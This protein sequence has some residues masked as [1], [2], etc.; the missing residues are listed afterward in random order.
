VLDKDNLDKDHLD[1]HNSDLHNH[2]D[3]DN[4]YAEE[5]RSTVLPEPVGERFTV[6]RHRVASRLD[7]RGRRL[8]AVT[9]V[10]LTVLGLGALAANAAVSDHAPSPANVAAT[11]PPSDDPALQEREDAAARPDRAERAT[12]AEPGAAEP[13]E[14]PEPEPSPTEAEEPEPEPEPEPAETEDAE[15][16]E[17]QQA[18]EETADWVHPMPGAATTSCYGMRWGV[19]HAGVDLA[20]PAGTPIRSVGAGTVTDAGWVFGGYGISVVVDHHNGVY[21]HYA[22]MSEAAVSPGDSVSPGQ[23][24]GYEGS[25]GD[26]TGPHLHFEVHSGMWN[27]IEPTSWMS[28]R[29]VSIGGC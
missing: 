12:P 14:S 15:E 11:A 13:K 4:P 26:S 5:D 23:T 27:Q 29:G 18:P 16:A 22:H 24:I 8:L 9:A 6:I 20:S 1:S 19:V 3:E 21:T 28:D 10:A 17:T 25:T 2:S 7:G